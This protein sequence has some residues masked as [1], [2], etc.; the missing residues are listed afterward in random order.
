MQWHSP[1]NALVMR[2]VVSSFQSFFISFQSSSV[3]EIY[4]VL[5][6]KEFLASCNPTDGEYPHG[7]AN[8]EA[9]PPAATSRCCLIVGSPSCGLC[10]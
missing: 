10:R 4:G 8:V 5:T 3:V 6:L 1:K 7:V 9:S 2:A